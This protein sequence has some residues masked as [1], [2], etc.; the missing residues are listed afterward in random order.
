MQVNGVMQSEP[1]RHQKY[2]MIVDL[3]KRTKRLAK[4][5]AYMSSPEVKSPRH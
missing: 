5:K 2:L 1:F 4:I 3:K